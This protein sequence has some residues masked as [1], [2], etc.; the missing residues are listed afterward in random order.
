[1]NSSLGRVRRTLISLSFQ[2]QEIQLGFSIIIEHVQLQ[3]PPTIPLIP[4]LPSSLVY[5][6]AAKLQGSAQLKRITLKL[7]GDCRMYFS[8]TYFAPQNAAISTTICLFSFTAQFGFQPLQWVEL[9]FMPAIFHSLQF[10]DWR[11]LKSGSGIRIS[12]SD[13]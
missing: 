2:V 11:S 5:S 6:E 13:R 9:I 8:A 10:I 12:T 7:K 4:S 1:M 3:I